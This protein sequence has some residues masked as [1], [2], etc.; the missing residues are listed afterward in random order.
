MEE[1]RKN[2]YKS[3]FS[4]NEIKEIRELEKL[5]LRKKKIN[6]FLM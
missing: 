5:S 4:L 1:E 6:N 3:D 2:L